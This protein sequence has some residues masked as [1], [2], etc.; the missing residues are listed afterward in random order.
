MPSV[1]YADAAMVAAGA[2]LVLSPACAQVELS[3]TSAD[4][5]AAFA[6]TD[7]GRSVPFPAL[8]RPA[9]RGVGVASPYAF[10]LSDLPARLLALCSRQCAASG[11]TSAEREDAL[12]VFVAAL[13]RS[14]DPVPSCGVLFSSTPPIQMSHPAPTPS[15]DTVLDSPSDAADPPTVPANAVVAGSAVMCGGIAAVPITSVEFDS[16]GDVLFRDQATV[17]TGVGRC[18]TRS[19]SFLGDDAFQVGNG[20]PRACTKYIYDVISRLSDIRTLVDVL[21]FARPAPPGAAEVPDDTV[22]SSAVPTGK[23][24]N[25]PEADLLISQVLSEVDMAVL[26]GEKALREMNWSFKLLWSRLTDAFQD[27][28]LWMQRFMAAKDMRLSADLYTRVSRILNAPKTEFGDV[29]NKVAL[30]P[31]LQA[32][33]ADENEKDLRPRLAPT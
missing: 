11:L 33:G 29:R 14:Q 15:D 32:N 9:L 1:P 8:Q 6:L 28:E 24:M 13:K 10:E 4:T 16:S 23:S 22:R 26:S 25:H 27:Q 7:A 19:A 2:H 18:G 30:A 12:R 20:A 3:A 17:P 31:N 21:S 5:V